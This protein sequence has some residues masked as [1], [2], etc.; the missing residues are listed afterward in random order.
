M[1]LFFLTIF[2][3]KQKKTKKTPTVS[4]PDN[5]LLQVFRIN[6][7]KHKLSV[8]HYCLIISANLGLDIHRSGRLKC[9]KGI[10]S[11]RLS[12]GRYHLFDGPTVL[13]PWRDDGFTIIIDE[14]EIEIEDFDVWLTTVCWKWKWWKVRK[15]N[16][17]KEVILRNCKKKMPKDAVSRTISWASLCES[18]RIST[19]SLADMMY[20]NNQNTWI[21]NR[22]PEWL[23]CWAWDQ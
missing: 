19:C 9:S 7:R 15:L 20:K 2:T 12:L 3:I 22:V 8:N 13:F 18:L 23:R 1:K 4:E 5:I 6:N 11:E 10:F 14:F 16:I 17:N 21:L